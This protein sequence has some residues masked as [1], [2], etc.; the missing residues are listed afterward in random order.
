MCISEK[1]D[2]FY[3]VCTNL[4][5]TAEEIVKINQLRWEI[6]ETFRILKSEMRSRPVFLQKD[7]RI[8]AH[9]L[10]C[11]LSLLIYRLLEKKIDES[12]TSCEIIE[13]LREMKMLQ[14]HGEGYIPTY[15]RTDLT[16][17]LHEVF[18]FRTDTEIVSTKNIKRILKNTKKHK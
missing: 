1:Y 13:T 8:K 3:G 11:F 9:F 10:T 7:D 2:G 17:K 5:S 12:A 14:C 18:N 15:T 16:D 4:E 6:E